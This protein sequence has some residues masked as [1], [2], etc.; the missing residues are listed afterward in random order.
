MSVLGWFLSL[1]GLVGLVVGLLQMLKGKKLNAV[2]FRA[3]AQI[4]QMGPG[5]ADAKG[6]VSTEGAVGQQGL[7]TAPMSGRPCLA[8][9]ITVERK[10]EKTERTEL[11]MVRTR[12]MAFPPEPLT[13]MAVNT[14]RWSLDRADHNLGKRNLILK[15]LDAAGLGFDS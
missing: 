8:F 14:T 3:P 4:A 12:P 2:P 9:E 13:S 15:T 6:L 1:I 7:L 5:A 11:E 10:W